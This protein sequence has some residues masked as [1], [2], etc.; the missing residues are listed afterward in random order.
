MSM[1][2]ILQGFGL[3]IMMIAEIGYL[4]FQSFKNRKTPSLSAF[5]NLCSALMLFLLINIPVRI[6]DLN[7]VSWH[8][9]LVFFLNAAFIGLETL[10]AYEWFIY[11]LTVQEA[12]M[13]K[14][15]K[16]RMIVAA[17]LFLMIF[18]IAVSY[19]T[20]W[21]FYVDANGMY[22]RGSMFFL[23]LVIPFLYIGASVVSTII[24][25]KVNKNRRMFTILMSAFLSSLIATILQVFSSGSFIHAGFCLAVLIVY[26]E[27]YQ[28]EIKQIE[29]MRSLGAVNK[30]LER[31]NEKL[32][33]TVKEL[34][35]SVE[36]EIAANNAKNDFLS[37]MSHDIRTPLNGILGIIDI[38]DRHPD[39][40]KLLAENR[41]KAKVAANHLVS[42]INDI[43]DMS[44]L[45]SGKYELSHEPFVMSQL[46][47]EVMII[48]NPRAE[49]SGVK[50]INENENDSYEY[51]ATNGSPLHIT[52]VLLN[53]VGNAIKYNKQD[54]S[55]SV[56]LD[57]ENIDDEHI[58]YVFTVSDT[59]IG[60]SE[61]YIKTLF[62][63]FSQEHID[64]RSVYDGSGLGMAITKALIEKMDGT[65]EVE[66]KEG[67]GSAFVIGITFEIAE[68]EDLSGDAEAEE[69]DLDGYNIL[70]AED[71][72][73][74]IDIATSL[75]ED[76]GAKVD[77]AENGSLAFEK[78]RSN[79][80]GTYDVIL[81][82]CMMPVM[83]GYEATRAIRGYDRPD[84]K[85]IPI[86]AMTA[87]AFADDV[88]NC[89]EA[90][91]NDHLAK[92]FE[93]AKV[94]KTIRKYVNKT[95]DGK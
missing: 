88:R 71:N 57:H 85:T 47:N 35:I 58:K 56:R 18:L 4:W 19:K 48:A 68:N 44:K 24:G 86:I 49:S 54:G 12:G 37:R 87:N 66:S 62:E 7:L 94:I 1:P 41:K 75:L 36:N 84:A 29:K 22:T 45:A 23:Q 15:P 46:L 76:S 59:G 92:P 31:V 11:F 67:E 9:D 72:E 65:I 8:P 50:L 43:L 69:D 52:R 74:N 95:Y 83:D 3:E 2:N 93:I 5:F 32:S 73:L 51:P 30:E 20:H 63:P 40:V 21:L 34:E 80:A 39:D 53:I 10:T 27:M 17:P 26:I 55:V 14:T 70:L 90:G 13:L 81:M 78:F 60:M 25:Y 89:L 38:N 77:V 82:D 61:E 79:A 91:M 6:S 42:L 64:A 33:E 16:K 28:Y